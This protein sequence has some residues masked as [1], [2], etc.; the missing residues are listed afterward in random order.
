MKRRVLIVD[1]S[2]S[3]RRMIEQALVQAG[4]EV[5]ACHSGLEALHIAKSER[6]DAVV[7]DLNMP[8][9][10]GLTLTRR[11]RAEAKS[12]R[13]PILILTTE[14]APSCKQEAKAAG[15]SGWVLKPFEPETLVRALNTVCQRVE[16][17]V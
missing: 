17:A 1:D 2:P 14:N 12:N 15:A 4:F 3:L 13:S 9:L 16:V 6:I 11:W 7:T 5:R 10:D 8:E